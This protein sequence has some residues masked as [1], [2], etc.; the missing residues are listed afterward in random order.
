MTCLDVGNATV[1]H[2]CLKTGYQIIYD[3]ISELH[4]RGTYL[5]IATSELEEF[6]GIT[7]SLDSTDAAEI[8]VFN[9]R[10]FS[11]SFIIMNFVLIFSSRIKQS[12][13][14]APV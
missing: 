6:E 10:I 2:I 14:P 8:Y 3:S 4:Y 5:H 11:T 1:C 12:N 7:P 9:D 13:D